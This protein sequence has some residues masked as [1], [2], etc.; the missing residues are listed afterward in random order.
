MPQYETELWE[1]AQ[2]Y[3]YDYDKLYALWQCEGGKH[4]GMFG[5]DGK[6]Y[7]AF[8]YWDDTWYRYNYLFNLKLNKLE[9]R[10]QAILTILIL[11]LPEGWRNWKW[12]WEN[13]ILN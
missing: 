2:E 11:K 13:R 3:D 5:D 12:C 9:F 1:V 10:D 4:D 8:Q 6:A 7:G